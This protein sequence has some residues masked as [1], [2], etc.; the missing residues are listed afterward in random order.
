MVQQLLLVLQKA[1]RL[2]PHLQQRQKQQQQ[3][4]RTLSMA[5]VCT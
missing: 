5:E 1:S 2:P 4:G 3:A